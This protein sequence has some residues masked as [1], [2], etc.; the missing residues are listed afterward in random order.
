MRFATQKQ[1]NRQK[2]FRQFLPLRYRLYIFRYTLQSGSHCNMLEFIDICR[3]EVR[4]DQTK[5][6]KEK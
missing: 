1:L 4:D 5:S 3:N 6:E 2:T